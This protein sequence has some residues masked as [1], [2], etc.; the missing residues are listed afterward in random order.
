MRG[1]ILVIDDDPVIREMLKTVLTRQ[2]YEVIVAED[3]VSGIEMAAAE[4][5]DLVITD[6]LL[7]KMHGFVVCKTIKQSEH[8][9]KVIVLTGLYTKLTYKWQ[10]KHEYDADE[11]LTKPIQPCDLIACVEKHLS[12]V[13]RRNPNEASTSP[14]ND[15]PFNDEQ[16][17]QDLQDAQ[18]R[19]EPMGFAFEDAGRNTRLACDSSLADH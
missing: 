9:P 1:K 16:Q 13:Q 10:V 8:P 2:D 19:I 3:G 6:G 17:A 5:P 7:P 15:N 18:A 12:G 11:L 14:A 4:Q